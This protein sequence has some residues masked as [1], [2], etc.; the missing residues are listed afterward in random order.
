MYV[1]WLDEIKDFRFDVTHLPGA[2]NPTDPLSRRGFADGDGPAASN[3]DTDAESQQELFSR[4]GRDSDTPAPT[5]LATIR[6]SWAAT[7]C[8]VA[9]E[10]A[11]VQGGGATTPPL[12]EGADLSPPYPS[13]F[14]PLAG[15]ELTLGTG[16]TT[17][18][19]PPAPSDDQIL[20]PA[21]V[22]Q[23]LAADLTTDTLF[24]P[25]VRGAAAAL[26]KLVDWLGTSIADPASTPKGRA[27]LVRCGLLY[28][29]GQGEADRLCVP[30]GSG[31]AACVR[32]C[33]GGAMTARLE[34]ISPA[35]RRGHWNVASPSGSVKTA[36]W[37]S[38]C[39]RA[40]LFSALRRTTVDRAGSSIRCHCRHDAGV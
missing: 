20:S 3:G 33:F 8:A 15:S 36:T 35:P 2:Q 32:R 37:P 10:F 29:R 28:R 30:A 14:V 11:H 1:R 21:F 18:P 17:A 25:I 26:G 39:A 23:R 7:R 9:A 13:M 27:F 12:R 4:R 16:M 19:S 40:R 6:A 34:V 31:P 22:Q 5:R 38:M 24:G